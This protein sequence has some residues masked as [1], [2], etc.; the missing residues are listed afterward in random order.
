MASRR[1]ISGGQGLKEI[2]LRQDAP[3]AADKSNIAPAV[4][5]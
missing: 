1:I 4:P 5:P 2:N 3:S